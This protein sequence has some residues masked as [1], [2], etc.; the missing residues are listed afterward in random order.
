[1][2]TNSRRARE[3]PRQRRQHQCQRSVQGFGVKKERQGIG[4]DGEWIWGDETRG[5]LDRW[6]VGW[7]AA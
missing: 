4:T 7:F 1:M 3:G 6:A 2:R 5:W